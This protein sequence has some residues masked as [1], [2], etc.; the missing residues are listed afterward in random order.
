MPADLVDDLDYISGR[1]GISRSG[2][3][4]GLLMAGE[5]RSLRTILQNIPENPTEADAKRFRGD[6]RAYIES[7]LQEL[8][9]MQGGLFDD[10]TD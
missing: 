4:S 10:S 3:V 5:L 8:Q 9:R 1:L 6:S 2:F 7:K